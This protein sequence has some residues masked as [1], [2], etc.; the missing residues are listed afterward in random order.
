MKRVCQAESG[1]EVGPE[2]RLGWEAHV[3]IKLSQGPSMIK[4]G[5][6]TTT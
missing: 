4:G 5:S 1:I 2:E 3:T 6:R